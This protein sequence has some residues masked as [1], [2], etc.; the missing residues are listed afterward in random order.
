M[1]KEQV[2]PEEILKAA[3]QYLHDPYTD[4][5]NSYEGFQAGAKWALAQLRPPLEGERV[6]YV[7]T[8]VSSGERIP[9]DWYYKGSGVY[10]KPVTIPLSQ[11]ETDK[12]MREEKIKK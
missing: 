9:S 2:S 11:L 3:S 7:E 10:F 4:L 12:G 5:H 8:K 1:N 6:V